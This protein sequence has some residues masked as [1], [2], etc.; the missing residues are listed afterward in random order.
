MRCGAWFFATLLVTACR[1]EPLPT[2]AEAPSGEAGPCAVDGWA[3]QDLERAVFVSADAPASGAG[4]ADA[5]TSSLQAAVDAAALHG[6]VVLVELGEYDED[7]VFKA[8][9]DGVAL[10]GRCRDGVVVRS[11]GAE[12]DVVSVEGADVSLSGVTLRGAERFGGRVIAGATLTLRDVRIED[13]GISGLAVA[14]LSSLIDVEQVE[15]VGRA[16]LDTSAGVIVYADGALEGDGLTLRETSGIG[17]D[18]KGRRSRAELTDLVVEGNRTDR[19][20]RSAAVQV[21]EGGEL[22]LIGGALRGNE[23]RGLSINGEGSAARV[24][25]VEVASTVATPEGEEGFGALV[26][27]G[28]SLE[29][30]DSRLED[31]TCA[32]VWAE[33]AQTFVRISGSAISRTRHAVCEVIFSSGMTAG[34]LARAAAELEIERSVLEGNDMYGLYVSDAAAQ[35]TDSA[36][37]GTRTLHT[38]NGHGAVAG[39]Q[40]RLTLRG[41]LLAENERMGLGVAG[42]GY[43]SLTGTRVTRNQEGGI[44]SWGEGAWLGLD[45]VEILYSGGVR[46]DSQP[47]DGE[48]RAGVTGLMIVGGGELEARSLVVWGNA[49]GGIAIEGS[50]ASLTDVLIAESTVDEGFGLGQGLSVTAGSQ[51]RAERLVSSRNADVGVFAEGDGTRF[52]V[53]GLTIEDTRPGVGGGGRGLVVQHGARL[54]GSDAWVADNQ[55]VG[56]FVSEPGTD[57]ELTAL[58]VLRTRASDEGLLGRGVVVQCGARASLVD[59]TLEQNTEVGVSITGAGCEPVEVE[60]SDL[61]IRDVE[62]DARYGSGRGLS[63][64][65]PAVVRVTDAEITGAR[66]IG[67]FVAGEGAEVSLRGVVVDGVARTPEHP[68]AVGVQVQGGALSGEELRVSDV[69]G[70]GLVS[71]SGA[72]VSLAGS[73]LEDT[74]VFGVGALGGSLTV[75]DSTLTSSSRGDGEAPRVGVLASASSDLRTELELDGVEVS[76]EHLAALWVQGDGRYVVRDSTLAGG[77]RWEERGPPLH[78][79]AAVA[80]DG[81]RAWDGEQGLLIERSDLSDSEG[82]DVLLH[83]ASAELGADNLWSGGSPQLVQQRCSGDQVSPPPGHEQVSA[84]RLCEEDEVLLMDFTYSLQFG[85][86]EPVR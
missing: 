39:G 13:S 55:S 31:N 76:G 68:V 85:A 54:V 36:M 5:P 20:G 6:G 14:N 28:A 62:P 78:G 57:V 72:S 42:G 43:A 50:T 52:E 25:S 35:V 29:I 45:G 9:H 81:V 34:V 69:E 65:G 33:G 44:Q 70:P 1:G 60:I 71:T 51:V 66:E 41:G 32:G 16:G 27:A 19:D 86:T 84:L 10:I 18:V 83:A 8:E 75:R 17:L 23:T 11:A 38:W 74:E 59:A 64:S 79:N 7:L 77:R 26:T 15:V 82:I 80:R 73:V 40:G 12:P 37:R 4:T 48:A 47:V 22:D 53:D 46:P 3:G 49:G 63:V 30:V 56:V 21:A 58:H 24:E 61:R 67:V 2:A